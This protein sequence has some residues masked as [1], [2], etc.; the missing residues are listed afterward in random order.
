MSF[1][2]LKIHYLVHRFIMIPINERSE[3]STKEVFF[4]GSLI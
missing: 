3:I 1:A 2:N 4:E